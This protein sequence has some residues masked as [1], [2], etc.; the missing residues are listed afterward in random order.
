MIELALSLPWHAVTPLRPDKHL[1]KELAARRLP[2]V[3]AGPFLKADLD[4]YFEQ[5]GRTFERERI[6]EG[7][8]LAADMPEV[9]ERD[10]V[11]RVVR[12]LIA[13]GSSWRGS[14]AAS[15]ALWLDSF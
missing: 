11:G 7:L 10:E 15:L 5:A 14:R 12:E 9:F 8:R 1:L 3:R 6:L 2:V 13:G 4:E